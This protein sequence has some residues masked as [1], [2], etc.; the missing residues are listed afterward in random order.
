MTKYNINFNDLNDDIKKLIFK[1]R[2]DLMKDDKYKRNFKNVLNHIKD[3]TR[4]LKDW[5]FN[6][7]SDYDD[8]DDYDDEYNEISLGYFIKYD[9]DDF[10][11]LLDYNDF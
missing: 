10:N 8:D 9:K 5:H 6:D 3:M 1:K 11:E 7:N 2:F 4:I